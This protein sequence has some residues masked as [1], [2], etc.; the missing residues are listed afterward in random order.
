MGWVKDARADVLERIAALCKKHES[1][2]LMGVFRPDATLVPVR[3]SAP[4]RTEN[5]L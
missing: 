4:L 3:R 2:A 1:K 5:T